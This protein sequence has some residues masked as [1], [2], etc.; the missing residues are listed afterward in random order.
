MVRNH[1]MRKKLGPRFTSLQQ[2][3]YNK[4]L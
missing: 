4:C 1:L 3:S 2:I